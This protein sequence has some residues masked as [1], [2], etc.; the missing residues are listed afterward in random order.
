MQRSFMSPIFPYL[1]NFTQ[2]EFYLYAKKRLKAFF[3]DRQPN[4]MMV[5]ETSKFSWERPL[6]QGSNLSSKVL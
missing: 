4:K 5:E 3:S 1:P 2:I 6:K